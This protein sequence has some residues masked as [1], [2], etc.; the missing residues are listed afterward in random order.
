MV[1]NFTDKVHDN[2]ENS[3][4]DISRDNLAQN[5]FPNLSAFALLKKNGGVLTWGDS[6]SGGDSSS[7]QS[8]IS[9]NVVNVFSN[10]LSFAALKHL[11]SD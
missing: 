8:S 2:V 5:T 1:T 10:N 9:S 6:A 4:S 11:N 3:T 7:V